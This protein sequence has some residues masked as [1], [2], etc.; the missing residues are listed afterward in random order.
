M[1]I[2][3]LLIGFIAFIIPIAIIVLII[4]A[5]VKKGK[6]NKDQFEESVRNIYIY[7]ILIVTIISIIMGTIATLRV[8]LDVI[9]P[10]E[11]LTNSTYNNEQ[12]Q[13]NENIIYLCTTLSLV[14][15]VTPV[16]IYHNKIAKKSRTDKAKETI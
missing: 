16:F 1:V 5:I 15:S 3:G 4:S 8:G 10:E 7:T 12:Q 13:K 2:L 9:L 6:E 14:I 11:A